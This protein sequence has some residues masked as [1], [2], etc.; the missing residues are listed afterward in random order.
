MMTSLPSSPAPRT[1]TLVAVGLSGVPSTAGGPI[2]GAVRAAG[3]D[4]STGAGA[5]T[6][7]GTAD[8]GGSPSGGTDASGALWLSE[9]MPRSYVQFSP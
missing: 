8:A 4:D 1:I 7:S 3:P 5:A 6:A 2:G 9:V